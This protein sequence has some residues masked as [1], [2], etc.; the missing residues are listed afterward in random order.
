M[1]LGSFKH[2]IYK[3]FIYKSYIFNIYVKTG[4]DIRQPTRID[5]PQNTT[6]QLTIYMNIYI[7]IYIWKKIMDS[8]P[9]IWEEKLT[10]SNPNRK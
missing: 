8:N 4:F 2:F 1:R 7:Y 9:T 3:I 5:M 6:N 10:T